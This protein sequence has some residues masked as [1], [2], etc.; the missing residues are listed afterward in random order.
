MPHNL[1]LHSALVK[2]RDIERSRLG[3]KEAMIY[4]VIECA[5]ALFV[6]FV[7]NFS[8]ISISASLFYYNPDAGLNEA[9][10]LLSVLG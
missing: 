7:I 1:F 5:I 9:S 6:S 3:I 4:N 8:I 10:S 2:T